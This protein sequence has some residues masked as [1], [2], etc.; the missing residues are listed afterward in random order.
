MYALAEDIDQ[1][2]P[3]YEGVVRGD[4]CGSESEAAAIAL[5]SN[6]VITWECERGKFVAI[7]GAQARSG[8]M[9][10]LN[11]YRGSGRAH[12]VEIRRDRTCARTNPRLVPVRPDMSLTEMARAELLT[13]YQ[14]RFW[15]TRQGVSAALRQP[16][17]EH[18]P[19]PCHNNKK[20]SS[21]EW[22]RFR[23]SGLW[24]QACVRRRSRPRAHFGCRALR[25]S[26]RLRSVGRTP[27][28]RVTSP[29]TRP[30][31]QG[32]VWTVCRVALEGPTG[33]MHRL[34]TL[35]RRRGRRPDRDADRSGRR[36][37]RQERPGR[38]RCHGA[39][40][41]GRERGVHGRHRQHPAVVRRV[42]AAARLA[43]GS[44]AST[45]TRSTCFGCS[46][47]NSVVAARQTPCSQHPSLQP[48]K[49]QTR[50]RGRCSGC[51]GP[52]GQRHHHQHQVR[53]QFP[54]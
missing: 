45:S 2:L 44:T 4:V 35:R 39:L 1:V 10:H 13:D 51:R 5:T 31:F 37:L 40:P 12:D 29:S 32:Q 25:Q 22:L 17:L 52:Q 7:D 49:Q 28:L 20:Q 19:R 54:L 8:G 42:V 50:P 11:D 14:A 48:S 23:V 34:R 21:N 46:T 26:H 27:Q 47:G 33:G 9:Q 53:P 16:V 38:P 15:R 6:H 3:S 36:R 41:D 43:R 24:P 18:K 30:G